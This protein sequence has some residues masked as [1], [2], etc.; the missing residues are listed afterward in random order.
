M[1][2]VLAGM[3][4]SGKTTVA[5]LFESSGKKIYDTDEQIV[6][7][8]GNITE[9]FQKFGE[10]YFRQLETEAVKKLCGLDGIVI[11]TGGGCLLKDENVKLLKGNGKIV[12]LRAKPQT[13]IE[14]LQGDTSRPLLAG[15]LQERIYKLYGER[16][17]VYESAADI[18]MDTDGQTPARIVRR[19]T[20][21]II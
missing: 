9:I 12:Y 19:I 10:S 2:I 16:A 5:K 7:E 13:L 1:N 4:G 15:G 6:K 3:P 14:R 20:E 18:I 17:S 11:A 21:L 8:H